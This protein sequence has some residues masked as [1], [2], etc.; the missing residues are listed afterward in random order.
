M[1][2]ARQR[3][4][5]CSSSWLRQLGRHAMKQPAERQSQ[6]LYIHSTTAAAAAASQRLRQTGMSQ[7]LCSCPMQYL[8]SQEWQP[9]DGLEF[10]CRSMRKLLQP[11]TTLL[12]PVL[13]TSCC[14]V[15]HTTAYTGAFQDS[16]QIYIVMEHCSG[17]DLLEQ[18]LREG[19]AMAEK[20]VVREVVL[21]TLTALAYLHAAGIIHR[22]AAGTEC[23]GAEQAVCCVL[24]N[25]SR[26]SAAAAETSKAT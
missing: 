9:S 21:P 5:C 23:S 6:G 18:L 17:G 1:A 10:P 16:K 22:C 14:S 24:R 15:P 19:R 11:T 2:V 8:L 12:L 25:C 7:G 26:G 4:T 20:R 13:Q 3:Q